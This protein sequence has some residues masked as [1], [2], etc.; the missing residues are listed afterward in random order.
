MEELRN[1]VRQE[2][3]QSAKKGPKFL[4]SPSSNPK[5]TTSE[6]TTG[7]SESTAGGAAVIY[8]HLLI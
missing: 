5:S 4:K 7:A 2:A 1:S 8:T 6:S 3:A